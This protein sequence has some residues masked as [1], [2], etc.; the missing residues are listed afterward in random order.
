MAFVFPSYG[1]FEV[2]KPF[3]FSHS[4]CPSSISRIR[5]LEGGPQYFFQRERTVFTPSKIVGLPSFHY[6]T[7]STIKQTKEIINQSKREGPN[8]AHKDNEYFTFIDSLRAFGLVL[9]GCVGLF[10]LSRVLSHLMIFFTA[11]SASAFAIFFNWVVRGIFSSSRGTLF[12]ACS[13]PLR[14]IGLAGMV[15]A[16]V[17]YRVP[18]LIKDV[19][20]DLQGQRVVL[21]CKAK[22]LQS[23]DILRELKELCCFVEG[24]RQYEWG[25]IRTLRE[26]DQWKAYRLRSALFV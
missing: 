25:H 18:D 3:R 8:T 9:G 26:T 22:H 20:A 19:H 1:P 16:C 2:H 23:K 14:G 12:K 15:L 7:K 5:L 17:M 4:F 10:L 13:V 24:V 21:A 11:A 6:S